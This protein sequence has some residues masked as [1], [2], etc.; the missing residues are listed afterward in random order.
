M[1]KP[2]FHACFRPIE[3][4]QEVYMS[5]LGELTGYENLEILSPYK[6]QQLTELK[7]VRRPNRHTALYYTGIIPETQKDL[8]IRTATAKDTLTVQQTGGTGKKEPL[9]MGLTANIGVKVVRDIYYLEVE[10]VSHTEDLDI[11]LRDRSFQDKEQKYSDLLKAV[12]SEYPGGDIQ[13]NVSKGKNLSQFT[14]QHNETDWQFLIRLASRFN[15]VVIPDD[16]TDKA[17]L[18]FGLPEGKEAESVLHSELPCRIGKNLSGYADLSQNC[19]QSISETDFTYFVVETGQ[20]YPL[21]SK[22]KYRDIK[23]V[24]AQSIAELKHGNLL[25]EYLLCPA[26]GLKQKPIFNRQIIGAALEGKVIDTLKDTVRVHFDIDQNQEKEKAWLFPY[27]SF[28]TAEGNS[29]FYCLPQSGDHVQVYFPT[30]REE[31]GVALNSVR[32]DKDSC[33]KTQNPDVK[34][35]GTNHDKEL[36]MSGGELSLTAKNTKEGQIRI[37]LNDDEGIEIRSD[38]EIDLAARK[39]MVFELDNKVAIKAKDEVQLI[40][41]DSSVNMDG[42]THFKGVEVTIEPRK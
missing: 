28:Y 36:M 25:Y 12:I 42:I 16:L 7:I 40:C 18:S 32:K 19:L 22:V 37:K 8:Y 11:K 27:S 30:V 38:N 41:G 26:S 4:D 14:L 3:L 34:Y 17:R 6:I 39:D 15:A 35:F 13:D 23:L 10:G 5:I 2:H 31:E 21:G 24:V 1:K 9:F 29:G 33:A 20:Y